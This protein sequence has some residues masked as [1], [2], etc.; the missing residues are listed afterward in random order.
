MAVHNGSKY[1]EEQIASILPQLSN[2]DEVVIVDDMSLDDTIAIIERLQDKRIHIVRQDSNRGV[3]QTFGHALKEA[4]GEILFLCDQ[5]DVWRSDKVAEC[6]KIFMDR[7][8]ITMV[9][10]NVQI[11]DAYGKITSDDKT[12]QRGFSPGVLSNLVRNHYQGSAMVF[13]RRILKCCLPFPADIPMHDIWI[14]IVN[15]FVGK[16][17]F[18][19]EPLLFY[20]RHGSNKTPDAHAPLKKMIQWR[21]VIVKNLVLLYLRNRASRKHGDQTDNQ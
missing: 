18:I 17:V 11:I 2:Y 16:S 15:Q 21:W 20:R 6:L 4:K 9:I 19:D 12:E 3:I 5:D 14:G 1:I 13:R 10:S 7:P 8:D